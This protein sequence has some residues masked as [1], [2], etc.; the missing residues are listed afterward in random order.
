MPTYTKTALS[1]NT[2]SNVAV[3]PMDTI[4]YRIL[5]DALDQIIVNS[6][7]TLIWQEGSY[8]RVELKAN[9]FTNVALA[10]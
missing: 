9:T 5:T 2:Y 6:V 10:T 7:D 4:R 3:Q 1:T 8:N